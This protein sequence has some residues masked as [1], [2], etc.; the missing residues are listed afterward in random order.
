MVHLLL[1]LA[2]GGLLDTTDLLGAVTAI[3]EGATGGGLLLAHAEAELAVGGLNALQ[4]GQVVVDQTEAGGL[5]TS[6]LGLHAEQGDGLL[7]GNLVEL[8][9]LLADELGG[10]GTAPVGVV[11]LDDELA[12][13]QQ[14]VDLEVQGAQGEISLLLGS[15]HAGQ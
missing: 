12:T 11:H 5:A 7:V 3:L 10:D 1:L 15:N 2:G 4:A 8:G 13:V 6:E 14:A 9:E